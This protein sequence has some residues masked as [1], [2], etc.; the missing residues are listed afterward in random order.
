MLNRRR[1]IAAAALAAAVLSPLAAGAQ[2]KWQDKYK[3]TDMVIAITPSENAAGTVERYTGLANYLTR[4]T[5]TPWV[6]KVVADYAAAIEAQKAGSIHVV[7][8]GPGSY[9]IARRVSNNGVEAF[10]TNQSQSGATGYYA[11]LWVKKGTPFQTIQDLKGK[12]LALVD[13]NSTTGNFAPRY[14]MDKAGIAVDSFFTNV[15]FAGSHENAIIALNNGTVDAAANWYNAPDDNNLASMSRKGMVKLDDFRVLWKSD[16]LAGA[17]YAY[18]TSIPEEGRKAIREAFY[19]MNKRDPAAFAK[20]TDGKDLA[21][22][23]V[24][25]KDYL[26]QEKMNDY[27][28]AL[29][30]K[31]S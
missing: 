31:R 25:H 11:V 2:A 14:F 9:V 5:G 29:R 26:D 6:L 30:K 16:L 23:P 27:I 12:K 1:L 28:D 22:A 4:E 13:P 15:V 3:G 10:A 17:P 8:Y 21:F 20:L 19:N 24:A 18:L 7:Y